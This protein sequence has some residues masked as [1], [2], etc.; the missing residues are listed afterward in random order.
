MQKAQKA[1]FHRIGFTFV[2]IVFQNLA[3]VAIFGFSNV[4][5]Q[6]SRWIIDH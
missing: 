3:S 1:Y 4:F 6:R 2:R 5:I